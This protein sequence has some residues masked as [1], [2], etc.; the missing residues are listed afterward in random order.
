MTPA[1]GRPGR[2]GALRL[3][4]AA[5]ALL[6]APAALAQL[7]GGEIVFGMVGPFTGASKEMGQEVRSGIEVA[8][9]AQNDAGGVHGRKL[10]LV[11]MDDGFEPARTTGAMRELLYGRKVFGIL[12]NVG[13]AGAKVA[14]PMANEKGILFFGAVSGAS[15]LRHN[16]PDR[17]VFNYRASYAEETAAIVRYLVEIRRIPAA[18]IAAFTQDDAF[19][20]AGFEGVARIMR[21]YR[22]D[23]AK[24]IRVRY[25]RN[26]ADVEDAAKEV[27]R[28][29]KEVG[30]V[31]MVATCKAAARFIERVRDLGVK[32]VVFTNVSD[33]GAN[34]LAD[35]LAQLGPGYGEGVVVTQVVPPPTAKATTIMRFQEQMRRYSKGEKPG[36]L[37]LEG[38]IT[39]R[40]IVEAL[41]RAGRELTLDGLI[42]TLEGMRGLDLGIGTILGFGPSEHQ[43]SHMVWGTVID[44]KG[45]LQPLDLQ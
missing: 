42:D 44:G 27:S 28:R 10:R 14:V 15:F 2:V 16:P 22:R 36:F 6:L 30:A 23:P 24:V 39:A 25:R 35:E 3:A 1:R 20:E 17:F 9:A 33:V 43:A 41:Q 5:A 45:Q 34:A 37:A 40:L 38:W 7:S 8:F 29:S 13:T 11:P 4:F 19:G 21:Q 31:V 32:G 26:T 18:R 12:G